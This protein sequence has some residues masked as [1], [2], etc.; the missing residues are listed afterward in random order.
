MHCYIIEA[1]DTF[2]IHFIGVEEVKE[3]LLYMHNNCCQGQGRHWKASKTKFTILNESQCAIDKHHTCHVQAWMAV[4]IIALIFIVLYYPLCRRRG[5]RHGRWPRGAQTDIHGN[6]L[7]EGQRTICSQLWCR[8]SGFY[9][10]E[11]VSV[12]QIFI[13]P[14]IP[15]Q[16]TIQKQMDNRLAV[17]WICGVIESGWMLFCCMKLIKIFLDFC[18]ALNEKQWRRGVASQRDWKGNRT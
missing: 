15:D 14:Q 6:T 4:V 1:T 13:Q 10:L 9:I 17:I 5:S 16:E 18:L 8:W 2:E 3:R 7:F 11:P 12:L